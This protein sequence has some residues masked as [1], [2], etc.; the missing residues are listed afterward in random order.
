MKHNRELGAYQ[1]ML[2]LLF[3][4]NSNDPSA[5]PVK[6]ITML[7]KLNEYW[8]KYHAKEFRKDR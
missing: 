4:M 6:A 3:E 5:I 2:L 8:A 1:K 7:R